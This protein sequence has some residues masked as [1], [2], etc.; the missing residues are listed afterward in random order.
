[1]GVSESEEGSVEGVRGGGVFLLELAATEEIGDT[2]ERDLGTLHKY[3]LE[4]ATN[5]CPYT[6]G[7]SLLKVRIL[8]LLHLRIYQDTLLNRH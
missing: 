8:V 4:L 6:R 3:Y 5:L 1:M 7:F 2:A